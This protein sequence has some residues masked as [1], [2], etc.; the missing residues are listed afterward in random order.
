MTITAI[1]FII[2]PLSLAIFVVR[3]RLLVPLAIV[4]S[5]FQ[6]ASMIDMR[7]GDSA[8]GI[9]PFFFVA[10]LIALRFVPQYLMAGFGFRQGDPVL[11]LFRPGLLFVFLGAASAFV[12]H[13][14]SPTW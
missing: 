3:P 14:S 6:A 11:T 1:G 4:A 12:L 5:V 8:V 2:I 10:I 9:S 13:S 7:G